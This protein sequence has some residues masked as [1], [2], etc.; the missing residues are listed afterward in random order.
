ML[1]YLFTVNTVPE[2]TIIL[3][4]SEK[5]SY[6]LECPIEPEKKD[7]VT[8]ATWFLKKKETDKEMELSYIQGRYDFPEIKL[9]TIENLRPDDEGLYICKKGI[10]NKPVKHFRILILG[11]WVL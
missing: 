7:E 4:L 5:K 2:D 8:F 1:L 3:D 11:E 6:T 9:M 10:G